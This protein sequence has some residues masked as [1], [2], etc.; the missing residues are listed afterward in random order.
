MGKPFRQHIYTEQWQG[1]KPY[2]FGEHYVDSYELNYVSLNSLPNRLRARGI[3][4]SKTFTSM[5][6]IGKIALEDP[7]RGFITCLDCSNGAQIDKCG[8]DCKKSG[9]HYHKCA[10]CGR[11]RYVNNGLDN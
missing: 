5:G 11:S 7:L 3:F 4:K 6:R 8:K 10:N 2:T 9:S 1:G